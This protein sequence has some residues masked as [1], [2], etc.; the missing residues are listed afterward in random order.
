MVKTMS[1]GKS[2]WVKVFSNEAVVA[3]E[4]WA[5]PFFVLS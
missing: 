5:E 4:A 2:P 1:M 3:A